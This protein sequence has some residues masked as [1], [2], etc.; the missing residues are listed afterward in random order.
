MNNICISD[1]LKLLNPTQNGRPQITYHPSIHS[2]NKYTLQQPPKKNPQNFIPE[3]ISEIPITQVHSIH[4]VITSAISKPESTFSAPIK[5]TNGEQKDEN[6]N[7]NKLHLDSPIAKPE[8]DNIFDSESESL[9]SDSS[10]KYLPDDVHDEELMDYA[11]HSNQSEDNG[12]EE[13]YDA[14]GKF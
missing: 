1:Y 13:F 3:P 12:D 9:L 14:E 5:Q 7:G 11:T 8:P 10:F 6:K 2:L 4:Q